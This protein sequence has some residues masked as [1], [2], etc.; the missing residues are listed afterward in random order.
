MP[1]RTALLVG[2]NYNPRNASHIALA[3]GK[4]APRSDM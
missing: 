4:S 3:M 2:I 1:R